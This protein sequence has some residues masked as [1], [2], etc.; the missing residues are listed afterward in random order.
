MKEE[1]RESDCIRTAELFTPYGLKPIKVESCEI[2]Y[3][4]GDK[5][6]VVKLK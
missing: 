2:V 3:E 5:T 4:P 1:K 6:V